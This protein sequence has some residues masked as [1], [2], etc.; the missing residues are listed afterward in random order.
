MN[1]YITFIINSVF[2][3]GHTDSVKRNNI[4]ADSTTY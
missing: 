4:I 2:K 3:S 1:D